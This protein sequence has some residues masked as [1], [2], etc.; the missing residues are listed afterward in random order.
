MRS[1]PLTWWTAAV[2][3]SLWTVLALAVPSVTTTIPIGRRPVAVAVD[4]RDHRVYVADVEQGTVI[5]YDTTRGVVGAPIT[6]GGQPSSLVVDSAGGRL[7]VGSR[8]G[9]GASVSVVNL[10]A[11]SARAFLPAGRPIRGMAYDPEIN[12]LYVGAADTGELLIVDG[13]SAQILERLRLGGLPTSIAVNEQNGEVAIA[14][15][16][17]A[18][19]L[20]VLDPSDRSAEPLGIPVPDGQPMHV[21][22][23]T[24]TG[25][26]FVTRAGLSPALLVLRPGSTAFDNAITTAPGV[27][28]LAVD[29]RTSRIY[30]AHATANLATVIDGASGTPIAVLPLDAGANHVAVDE[31]STPTRVYMLDTSGALL[32]V[33][34][35]Q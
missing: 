27:T 4:G 33:L 6:V 14:V 31:A 15:Q 20:T 11:G 5:P 10:S 8:D 18:P 17:P 1:R 19:T 25:K 21:D 7:F 13:S 23:D 29:S 3:M 2:V 28:G 22:V 12:R 35:D 30:L 16:G 9:A 26:F 32:S 24:T 34:T